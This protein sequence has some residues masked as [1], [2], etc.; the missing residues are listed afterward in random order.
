METQ[1]G[2]PPEVAQTKAFRKELDEVLQRLKVANIPN[3]GKP[4]V[5]YP[6]R[7]K[8][9][10]ITKLQ[11]SIMWLGMDLKGMREAGI[12]EGTA[13]PYPESY[14]PNSGTVEATADGLKL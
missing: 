11:E 1:E 6:S 12:T 3:E 5:A 7:E 14:N 10:A 2:V 8:A 13:N 4:H 9:L